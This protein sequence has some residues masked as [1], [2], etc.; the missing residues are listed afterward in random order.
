MHRNGAIYYIRAV[1][2]RDISFLYFIAILSEKLLTKT[3]RTKCYLKTNCK[4]RRR[5]RILQ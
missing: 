4:F 1:S 3:S 2:R 5:R